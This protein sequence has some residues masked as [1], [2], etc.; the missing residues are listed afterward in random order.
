MTDI[1]K[2]NP[3]ILFCIFAVTGILGARFLLPLAQAI[4]LTLSVLCLAGFFR[5]KN[6]TGVSNLFLLLTI[7][8]SMAIRFNIST[9]LLP[10][11]HL[12]K[13]DIKNIKFI[14]GII[15]DCFIKRDGRNRFLLSVKKIAS[16]TE[17]NLVSG[18]VLLR[19]KNIST[20]FRYGDRI[21]FFGKLTLPEKKRFP[22]QFDYSQYLAE[23]DVYHLLT[24]SPSDTFTIIGHQQGTFLLQYMV[25]PLRA[26]F[27]KT[28]DT[29]VSEKTSALLKALILG[30]KQNLGSEM[31][32]LFQQVGVVHVLAISGLHVGF[33]IAFVFGFASLLRFS[34]GKKLAFLVTILIIY[35][36]LV[37]FKIPVIRASAMAIMFLIAK[38]IER[39]ASVYNIIFASMFL[40]LMIDPR[41]LFKPGFQFSFLAVLSIIY[42]YE[43]L[44]DILPLNKYLKGSQ[45]S[46]ISRIIVKAI[47]IPLLVSVAAVLGTL[48]LT[49]FY[50]G[51]IPLYAIFANLIIIPMAGVI[52]FLS[53]FLLLTAAL[54]TF[55]ALGLGTMIV[56]IDSILQTV[57]ELFAQLP[58]ASIITIRPTLYQILLLYVWIY[59]IFNIKTYGGVKMLAYSILPV[60]LLVLVSWIKAADIL[61]VTFLDV[62][63]GDAAF[64]EFPNGKNMLIDAG[65]ASRYWNYGEKTVL[66]FLQ[67]EGIT[68]INYLVGSHAH[69]DH[70]GGFPHLLENLTVDTLVLELL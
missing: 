61:K 62:G 35:V 6:R 13:Y 16:L 34:Q 36:I 12:C 58:F 29:Y 23:Q 56:F 8:G 45:S 38:G 49:L 64:L 14:E 43:R 50:Y 18:K 28:F 41:E 37:R 44:N 30:E 42:G 4:I 51:S 66:P 65:S 47:W 31:L 7:L 57:T 60:I 11:N 32:T 17:E 15:D 22:G 70:I 20:K 33:I 53:L 19:T 10:K 9:T 1:F 25:V 5:L 59:L 3:F 63:Q 2:K 54:S 24:I 69:N 46:W 55:L 21:R 48:P 68:R 39:R 40:I 26:Y 67:S 27:R 52:V